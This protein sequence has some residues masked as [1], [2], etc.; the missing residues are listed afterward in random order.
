MNIPAKNKGNAIIISIDG[1]FPYFRLLD[2]KYGKKEAR[3][4]ITKKVSLRINSCNISLEK[5][6]LTHLKSIVIN[7]I[8]K[9]MKATNIL[10]NVRIYG[11]VNHIHKK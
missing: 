7:Q 8:N 6:F 10:M 4:R 5:N 9:T 11:N 2:N 1:I 3:N